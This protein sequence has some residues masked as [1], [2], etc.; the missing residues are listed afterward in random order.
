VQVTRLQRAKLMEGWSVQELCNF[1][2]DEGFEKDVV[3]LFRGNR[4]RGPVLP[5]LTLED[6]KELGV[7]ALRDR[8]ILLKLFSARDH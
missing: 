2:E 3:E 6:L 7:A 8:K 4:I 5:L 1:I